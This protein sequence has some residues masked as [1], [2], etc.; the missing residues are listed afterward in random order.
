MTKAQLEEAYKLATEAIEEK[1]ASIAALQATIDTMQTQ[2]AGIEK[3]ATQGQKPKPQPP[4]PFE[5]NGQIYRFKSPAII[6][7]GRRLQTS[8]LSANGEVIAEILSVAGQR[9]LELVDG[10]KDADQ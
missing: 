9:V 1:D 3:A 4:T 8:S 6:W 10:E 7:Q 2:L 5:Y